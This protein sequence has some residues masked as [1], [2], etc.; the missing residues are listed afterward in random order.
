MTNQSSRRVNPS[1]DLGGDVC[2]H[3]AGVYFLTFQGSSCDCVA[4]K[5]Q[6]AAYGTY[7][8]VNYN[9]CNQQFLINR[10]SV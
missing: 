1:H 9:N 4:N 3:E 6:S 7:G 2:G 10:I 5:F 8:I